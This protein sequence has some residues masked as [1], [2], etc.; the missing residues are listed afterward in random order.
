MNNVNS[1]IH[2]VEAHS[3]P[4][5]RYGSCRRLDRKMTSQVGVSYLRVEISQLL[6]NLDRSSY[7]THAVGSEIAA[8]E[9]IFVYK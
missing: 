8:R 6:A 7:D 3:A 5:W 2:T 9:H 4:L 1:A